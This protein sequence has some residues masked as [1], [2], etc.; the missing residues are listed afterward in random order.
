MNVNDCKSV[1]SNDNKVTHTFCFPE[2]YVR[3][4][5]PTRFPTLRNTAMRSMNTGI[6][7]QNKLKRLNIFYHMTRV[8][9]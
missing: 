9:D 3:R 5:Q 1:F 6:K 4:C 7:I 8:W 2:Y